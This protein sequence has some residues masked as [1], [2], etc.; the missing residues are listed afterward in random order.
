M[1][2]WPRPADLLPHAGAAVL[3][4]EVLADSPEG[5]IV[6]AHIGSQNPYF[7]PGHGVPVWVGM[8]MM[9]QAVAIHGC[10][11][12]RSEICRPRRG[13]LLG[14]RHFDG[15]VG[16]F[17]EG[18]QLHIHAGAVVGN[19]GGGLGACVC[20]IEHQGREL[21]SATLTIVEEVDK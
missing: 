2:N 15:R 5:I 13:M 7:V 20:R 21:A 10:L 6:A 16:W 12:A 3:V 9:A 1:K 17:A 8:E 4:D 11:Q 19:A 14:T 18:M